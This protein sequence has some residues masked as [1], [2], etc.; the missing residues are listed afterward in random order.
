MLPDAPAGQQTKEFTTNLPAGASPQLLTLG[1]DGNIWF[2]DAV[3]HEIGRITPEG[4]ITMFRQPT[5]DVEHTVRVRVRGDKTSYAVS[6]S[7][8]TLRTGAKLK[9]VS[10]SFYL[11]KGIKHS[12]KER[13]KVKV[14][15]KMTTKTETIRKRGKSV[16]VTKTVTVGKTL[17]AKLEIC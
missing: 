3:N 9:F 12:K 1:P 4:T 10:A 5:V 7:A 2:V 6:L 16:K 14:H 13:R 11:D 15:G 17:T 8:K